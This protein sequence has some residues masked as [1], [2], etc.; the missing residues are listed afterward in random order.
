MTEQ[1][2]VSWVPCQTLM[3]FFWTQKFGLVP[4]LFRDYPGTIIQQ[5]GRPLWVAPQAIPPPKW[6][7]FLTTLVILTAHRQKTT[8]T[9]WQEFKTKFVSIRTWQQK[10]KKK[11]PTV[12]L[13]ILQE[14]KGALRE[15]ATI[16]QWEFPSDDISRPD[17]A[18]PSTIGDEQQFSHFQ[19][20]Y[21]SNVEFA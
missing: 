1:S 10:L 16:S 2:H 4:Q 7:A 19:Q 13:V 21:R 14:K 5:T 3:S 18:G 8:L 11:F 20:H 15:S 9:W 17:F 6:G 12:P